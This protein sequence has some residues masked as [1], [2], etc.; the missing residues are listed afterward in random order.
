[1][2]RFDK[3]PFLMTRLEEC[4]KIMINT[5]ENV[6]PL[7]DGTF[8]VSSK[9]LNYDPVKYLKKLDKWIEAYHL[10]ENNGIADENKNLTSEVGFGS[11]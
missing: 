9:T 5:D 11:I 10:S 8:K 6:R 1:M 7:V 2:N 3:N 4:K